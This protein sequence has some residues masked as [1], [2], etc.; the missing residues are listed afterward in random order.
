MLGT[1]PT[2]DAG[3]D[4]ATRRTAPRERAPKRDDDARFQAWLKDFDTR[5]AD[6]TARQEALL[7][8]LGVEPQRTEPAHESV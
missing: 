2:T 5:M 3:P 4:M 8:N 6:L 7:R 1:I